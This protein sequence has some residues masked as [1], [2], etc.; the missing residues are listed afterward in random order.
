MAAIEAA[1]AAEAEAVEVIGHREFR[2]LVDFAL[3]GAA[4][5]FE[6]RYSVSRLCSEPRATDHW[7]V[8]PL[9]PSPKSLRR[10]SAAGPSPLSSGGPRCWRGRDQTSRSAT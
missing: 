3:P 5:A 8:P 4:A 7:Q 10:P 1:E 6:L 9:P 2:L